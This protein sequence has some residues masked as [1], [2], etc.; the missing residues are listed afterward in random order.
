[1]KRIA[2]I[3]VALATLAAAQRQ[4]VATAR[5]AVLAGSISTI[6]RRTG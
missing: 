4:A 5:G 2:W 3:V 1:M 6:L